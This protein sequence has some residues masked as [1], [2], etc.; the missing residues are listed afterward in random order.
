MIKSMKWCRNEGGIKS[1]F[2]DGKMAQYT[3]SL[4]SSPVVRSGYQSPQKDGDRWQRGK[5]APGT[6]KMWYA[7]TKIE[8]MRNVWEHTNIWWNCIRWTFISGGR[9]NWCYNSLSPLLY[10]TWEYLKNV[11]VGSWNEN[12]C[13]NTPFVCVCAHAC[14]HA[15]AHTHTQVFY[16]MNH[17]PSP[18]TIFLT[19][20]T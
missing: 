12:V 8:I 1:N 15:R 7:D 20:K 16:L 19:D 10:I 6:D 5:W 18:T 11:I 3:K 14:V 9:G 17:L 4:L 2:R 13:G